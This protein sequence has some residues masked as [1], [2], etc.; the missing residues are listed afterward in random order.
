[1]LNL[2]AY[3]L[4]VNGVATRVL[5]SGESGT[6]VVFVHGAGGRAERWARNLDA[7]A[8]AGYHAYAPDLPGHG[9][10]AKGPGVACSVPA[11]RDFLA[12][13][14]DA[15]GAAQAVLIGTSLG[16]H[17]AA[18]YA[19]GNPGRVRA[20]VL[21]GSLG[22]VP[23][24]VEA[25]LRVQA[26]LADQGREGIRAKL[27][28]IFLDASLV[29]DETVEEDFRVNNSPGAKESFA[30]LGRYVAERLDDDVVGAQL[31]AAGLPTL[32]VWGEQ[33]RSVDLSV[34]KAAAGVIPGARLV[35]LPDAGHAP[36]F[37]RP[38]AF[39][40]AVIDFLAA[41]Q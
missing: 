10:A 18:A 32:L 4:Y 29:T 31:A 34:G 28:R 6:P 14:V 19:A 23:V 27:Q 25:R 2:S 5:V 11:Y 37:E 15:I 35:V 20:L 40:R 38:E 12:G 41:P 21:A 13:F 22:L 1:M 7:L 8:A 16:G 39:N 30:A 17:V 33:D 36:Y 9:F 3:P 26:G 24:G